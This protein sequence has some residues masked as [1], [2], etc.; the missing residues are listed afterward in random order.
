MS[1]E[2]VYWTRSL[3]TKGE[4]FAPRQAFPE[5]GDDNYPMILQNKKGQILLLWTRSG[6]GHWA[7][8]EEKSRNRFAGTA[9]GA[10]GDSTNRP[11][12][13]VKPNGDFVIVL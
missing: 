11:S 1:Q 13:F 6:K 9:A 3:D 12:A 10:E 8:Y 2:K 7:I 5:G 4:K